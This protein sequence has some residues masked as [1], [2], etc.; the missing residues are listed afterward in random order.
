MASRTVTGTNKL[1]TGGCYPGEQATFGIFAG[2]AGISGISVRVTPIYAHYLCTYQVPQYC[3]G[4]AMNSNLY[5]REWAV[6]IELVRN[7]DP[8]GYGTARPAVTAQVNGAPVVQWNMGIT[9]PPAPHCTVT[10]RDVHLGEID[11]S[12]LMDSHYSPPQSFN[13]SYS[14]CSGSVNVT[15]RFQGAAAAERSDLFATS[16]SATGVGIRLTTQDDVQ[17]SPNGTQFIPGVADGTIVRYQVRYERIA[18]RP[19]PGT[20]NATLTITSTFD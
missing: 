6:R 15:S 8:L 13:V 12:D 10:A 14:G 18:A 9:V 11:I 16:G 19:T 17:I 4:N 5:G 3:I 2:N 1:V 20:A 7:W